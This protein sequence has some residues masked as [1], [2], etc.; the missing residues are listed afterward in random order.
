[1]PISLEFFQEWFINNVVRTQRE[2]YPFL[3]F[4]KAVCSSLIAKSFNSTCFDDALK[5]HLRFDTNIFNFDSNYSGKVVS[6]D[7]LATSKASADDAG[8]NPLTKNKLPVIPS[9][10]LYS[11]DSQPSSEGDYT[12][13]LKNGIYHYYLGAACG[14]AKK[15]QFHRQNM[16]YYREARIGRTSALSAVQLRELYN[17]EISMIGNNLHRNGQYLFINPIVIVFSF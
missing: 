4:I 3:Q 11:V 5:F 2:K 1:M 12:N 9:V 13:D 10:V 15:I 7:T 6:V 16:P 17:A 14:I 8:R